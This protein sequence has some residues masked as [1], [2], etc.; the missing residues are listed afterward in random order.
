MR[1]RIMVAA[2]GMCL[3]MAA[4]LASA[5]P[6]K[7]LDPQTETCRVFTPGTI[8][9]GA[10]L[11]RSVCKSCHSRENVVGA[12]FLHSESKISRAWNRIFF[13]RYPGCAKDGAWASLTDEQLRR[14]NDFL[15][16]NSAD[17]YDPNSGRDCG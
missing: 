10:R 12:P 9:E 15:Y 7:R 14:V 2:G 13:K 11:F 6:A 17:S 5:R 3:V 8:E 1:K 16:M 4:G